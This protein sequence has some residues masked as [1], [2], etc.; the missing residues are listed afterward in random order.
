MPKNCGGFPTRMH[1]ASIAARLGIQIVAEFVGDDGFGFGEDLG[2]KL[3]ENFS[4]ALGKLTVSLDKQPD[5]ETQLGLR[6]I[7]P[8]L[9]PGHGAVVR[10]QV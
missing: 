5:E 3:L 7:E 1:Q 10:P 2:R 9:E 6:Q 4:L 8:G